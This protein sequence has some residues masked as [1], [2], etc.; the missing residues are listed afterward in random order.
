MISGRKQNMDELSE[1]LVNLG[2]A[3]LQEGLHNKAKIFCQEAKEIAK[4]RHDNNGLD[5]ANICLKKL[6]GLQ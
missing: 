6:K 3:Y 2:N 5:E 1:F 4:Q